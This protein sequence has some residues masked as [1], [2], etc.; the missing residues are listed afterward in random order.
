MGEC[1]RLVVG[2]EA[3]PRFAGV[4]GGQDLLGELWDGIESTAIH[5]AGVVLLAECCISSAVVPA[6]RKVRDP[7]C[8]PPYSPH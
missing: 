6:D 4:L 8:C 7:K 1:Y 5:L 3:H 2:H